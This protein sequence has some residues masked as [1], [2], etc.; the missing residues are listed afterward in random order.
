MYIKFAG[1]LLLIGGTTLAGFRKAE[2]LKERVEKL[3]MLKRMMVMMQGEFRFRHATLSEV[4]ENVSGKMSQPFGNI[5]GRIAKQLEERNHEGFQKIWED[6]TL[7]L[8]QCGGIQT[9]EQ[10]IFEL[11][12]NGLGYLDLETQID[13]LQ[14]AVLQM[15]EKI[16][17]AKEQRDREGKL[18][19]TMGMTLG[20][21]FVLLVV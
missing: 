7:A 18:Y 10:R 16:E 4:L 20:A 3:E 1:C 5:F 13:T 11:L 19:R 2:E 14:L 21:L 12:G 9:S 15:E 17:E 6:G 8:L